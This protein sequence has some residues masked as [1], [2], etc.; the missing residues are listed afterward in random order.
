MIEVLDDALGDPRHVEL[1]IC[2]ATSRSPAKA[3]KLRRL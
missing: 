2:T 3:S 1:N